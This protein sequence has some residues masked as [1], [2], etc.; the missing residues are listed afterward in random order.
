MIMYVKIMVPLDGS[1]LAE[2]VFP[3][4][5]TIAKGCGVKNVI[6]VRAVEP[7]YVPQYVYA[8]VVSAISSK[9]VDAENKAQAKK[10]LDGVVS[11]LNLN[12]AQIK[13][14]VIMGKPADVLADYATK[15]KVDLIVI[16]THGRSGVSRWVWGSVADR[17]LRSACIPVFMVRAPGCVP[18][19]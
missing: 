7:F 18:G 4:L 13:T 11:R 1:E 17:I 14:D 12:G 6:L 8:S 19:I 5:E 2:C 16:A 9:E 3:H 15:N 10:Y